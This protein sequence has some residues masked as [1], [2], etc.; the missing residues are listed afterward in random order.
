MICKVALGGHYAIA[1]HSA[2]TR[3][4]TREC[5]RYEK[6]TVDAIQLLREMIAIPS[7]NP[8]RANSG[9]SVERGM[10]DF[11][12]AVLQ[13]AG[14]D[15]ERQT[16]SDGRENVIGIVHPSGNKSRSDRD[17]LLFNSHMDTVPVAN[18]S[19]DPFDPSVK[20]DC[21]FGRGSCDAKG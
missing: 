3:S 9:E 19:I 20:D 11:I 8:M 18:M 15:C 12:E 5:C 6:M 4:S 17:G 7:V 16:V 1:R 2:V 14:I 10:S 13:R 21:V